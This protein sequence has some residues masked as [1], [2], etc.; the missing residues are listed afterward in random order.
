MGSLLALRQMRKKS[1]RKTESRLNKFL[2]VSSIVILMSIGGCEEN[3][4][5]DDAYEAGYRA[6][7]LKSSKYEDAYSDGEQDSY[8]D[9]LKCSIESGDKSKSTWQTSGGGSWSDYYGC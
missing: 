8:C 6:G 5:E 3:Y 9:Y 4:D 2:V 7:E 1:E